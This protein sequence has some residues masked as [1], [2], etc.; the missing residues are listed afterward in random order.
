MNS[1]TDRTL[2]NYRQHT[3][4]KLIK[5]LLE[6]PPVNVTMQIHFGHVYLSFTWKHLQGEA[7]HRIGFAGDC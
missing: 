7:R 2:S 5:S 4:C 1:L 6:N 3:G